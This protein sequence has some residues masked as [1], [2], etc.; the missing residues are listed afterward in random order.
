M[1]WNKEI[2][3]ELFIGE[4][5]SCHT[6]SNLYTPAH[7]RVLTGGAY[8]VVVRVIGNGLGYP[9]SNPDEAVYIPHN[10]NGF[11]KDRNPTIPALVSRVD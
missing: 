11:E 10:V 3:Q 2:M 7:T 5:D 8:G 6:W 9:S 1:P 4:T